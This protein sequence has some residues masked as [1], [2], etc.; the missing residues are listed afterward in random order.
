MV[1]LGFIGTSAIALQFA[2][3][4]ASTG[5][6]KFE[7]VCSR[8]AETAEAF[9]S[10]VPFKKIYTSLSELA[11]DTDVD[12]IYIASP[13]SLHYEQALMMLEHKKHVLCEKP[14]TTAL[15]QHRTLLDT[16]KKHGVVLL[17]AMRPSFDPAYTALLNALPKLDTIRRV[18]FSFCQYSSRY[19]NF[20]NGI[21]ANVF[22]PEMG[23]G[24][25]LDI[26]IYP[27]YMLAFLFGMP[28]ACRCFNLRL[29]NG[30]DGLGEIIATYD[31]F[32]GEIS[33]SKI[34][35][36]FVPSRIE[37]EAGYIT[38]DKISSPSEIIIH[39]NDGRKKVVYKAPAI[40]NMVY[41]AEAFHKM[42]HGALSADRW[43]KASLD[44]IAIVEAAFKD[45]ALS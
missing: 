8:R 9:C 6:F 26:G 40:N 2:D 18:S 19:D 12:A 4:A 11:D 7:A 43:H 17:E 5:L 44:A 45:A 1:R 36:S 35:N 23:G 16:A 27:V 30:V 24:A 15:S 25:L 10:K 39:F 42:I 3:A 38:I 41:E 13:N 20:N 34:T 21:I 14:M 28:K 37:G 32:I 31:G 29:K 33:Y 22:N